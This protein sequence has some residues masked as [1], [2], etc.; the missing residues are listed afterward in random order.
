MVHTVPS[1]FN[2][3]DVPAAKVAQVPL[4]VQ[5]N[6]DDWW[7]THELMQEV[8]KSQNERAEIIQFIFL[9]K[10]RMEVIYPTI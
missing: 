8:E 4:C 1:D 7:L 5:K 6:M 10:K 3:K 2:W 9:I